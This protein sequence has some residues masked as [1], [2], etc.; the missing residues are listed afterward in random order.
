MDDGTVANTEKATEYWN[1]DTRWDGSNH[2]S[3]ATG[4]QW[5]HERLYLSSKG[6][7]Y[8]EHWSDS[9]GST[10]SAEWVSNRTAVAWLLANDH[11]IPEVL[12]EAAGEV[13]E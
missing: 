1:E 4:R 13:E 2:I 7:F 11:L 6:R 5:D 8:L 10:P 12:K 9:Q 3:V